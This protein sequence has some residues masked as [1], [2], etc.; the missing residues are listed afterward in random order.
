[1]KLTDVYWSTERNLTVKSIFQSFPLKFKLSFQLLCQTE[2]SNVGRQVSD[3]NWPELL[4]II[5]IPVML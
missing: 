3:Q 4:N 5:I 1:M 2:K